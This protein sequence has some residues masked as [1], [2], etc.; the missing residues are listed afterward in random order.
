[1]TYAHITGDTLTTHF[2]HPNVENDGTRD[3]D[4][5]DPTIRTERGWLE[6]TE[7]PR[8][9]DTTEGTH[10]GTVQL[11]D[12]I[13]T[14]VWTFRPWTAE[15]LAAQAEQAARFDSIED[16]LARIEAHLWPPNTTPGT[17]ARTWA[18]H[19]GVWPHG[20]LLDDGGIIWRNTA[21]VPLTEPPSWFPGGG[22]AFGHLFER[23]TSD[24]QGDDY[25]AWRPDAI[26][27][28]GDRVTNVGRAWECL[29]GHGPERQGTW[30]PGVAHTVWTDLGVISS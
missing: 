23:V 21:G 27:T 19:G 28:A 8:A 4:L 24:A 18:E 25:P 11:V 5:R 12:G 14:R 3:W 6:V 16:R 15:E 9:A 17:T 1:M 22:A 10:D 29:L 30:A 20:T 7:T 2:T 13:P 26:Y